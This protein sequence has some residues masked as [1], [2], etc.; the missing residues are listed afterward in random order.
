VKNVKTVN[1]TLT[2]VGDS[3]NFKAKLE[4]EGKFL[5]TTAIMPNQS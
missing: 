3:E 5:T 2:L 4:Q 1:L